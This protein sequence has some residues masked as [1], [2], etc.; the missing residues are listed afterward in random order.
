M[1]N[2]IFTDIDGVL[3]PKYK[4]NW[5]KKCINNYNRI[6]SDLNLIAIITSTWRVRYTIEELQK[7]FIKQGIKVII[8]DYTPIL[9]TDRGLEIKK[10]VR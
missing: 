3:N 10:M 7:I 5:D 6:C 2:Y 4:K 8:N 9:N 1:N